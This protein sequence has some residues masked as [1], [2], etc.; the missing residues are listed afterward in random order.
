MQNDLTLRKNDVVESLTLFLGMAI[1]MALR[2]LLSF[3][4]KI[5]TNADV[6]TCNVVIDIVNHCQSQSLSL[7]CQYYLKKLGF[8]TSV[9]AV[10]LIF[11]YIACVLSVI[12]NK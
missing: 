9:S 10:V 5:K 1:T 11:Q 8:T 7:H 4:A 12:E 6:A 3:N 2:T